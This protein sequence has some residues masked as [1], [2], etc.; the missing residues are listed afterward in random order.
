[1]ETKTITLE[2]DA[3][4]AKAYQSAPAEAPS[5][6]QLLLTLWLRELFVRSTS[7]KDVSFKDILD[8]LSDKTQARGLTEQT[9]EEMLR[10]R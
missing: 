7:L 4:L 6:L 8:N 3:E 10:D 1:M 9:L 2:V 5:K